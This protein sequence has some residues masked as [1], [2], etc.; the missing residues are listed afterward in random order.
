[1]GLKILGFS[2]ITLR[3]KNFAGMDDF[4]QNIMGFERVSSV[5]DESGK[6]R[7]VFYSLPGGQ[8]LE[9]LPETSDYRR[10]IDNHYTGDNVQC[11][12]SHYHVCL[13]ID[14]RHQVYREME[15]KNAAIRFNADDSV[16]M[17]GSWCSFIEDPENNQW[18]LMEFSPVSRQ[19]D[20]DPC[21]MR[22]KG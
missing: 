12:R 13:E 21:D 7:S 8:K 19:L 4:Y 16:G 10:E 9:L 14:A 17:C 6:E 1:M 22:F 11:N 2:G 15:K 20:E 18:E 5:T 3:T